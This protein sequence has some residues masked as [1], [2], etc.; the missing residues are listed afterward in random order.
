MYHTNIPY[1]HTLHSCTY[2]IQTYPTC[3]TFIHI[4]QW[5][6]E[7]DYTEKKKWERMDKEAMRWACGS[8]KQTI[9]THWVL[10]RSSNKK[11]KCHRV[12]FQQKTLFCGARN[13]SDCCLSGK[14]MAAGKGLGITE[15]CTSRWTAPVTLAQEFEVP[16]LPQNWLE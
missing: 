14:G 16:I 13:V 7:R 6:K 12:P 11:E 9:T 4:T 3:I 10:G 2:H 1:I 8:V 15:N 5:E